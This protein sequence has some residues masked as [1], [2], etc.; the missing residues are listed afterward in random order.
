MVPPESRDGLGSDGGASPTLQTGHEGPQLIVRDEPFAPDAEVLEP[1]VKPAL[2]LSA[3]F[4]D[5]GQELNGADCHALDEAGASA[6]LL[7][8]FVQVRAVPDLHESV[9]LDEV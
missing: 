1:C 3:R 4:L 7:D 9:A 8:A 6:Q 2:R 5:G